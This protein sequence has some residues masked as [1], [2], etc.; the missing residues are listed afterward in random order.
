M[1][2]RRA[3]EK[4]RRKEERR[5]RAEE[6]RS[7]SRLGEKVKV[8]Q[9]RSRHGEKVRVIQERSSRGEKAH[10]A[11]SR[12]IA[13]SSRVLMGR[14]EVLVRAKGVRQAEAKE[15]AS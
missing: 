9:E 7:L 6:T 10:G 5:G 15:R 8:V 11:N 4:E 3:K 12:G 14:R 1:E 13:V 2:V